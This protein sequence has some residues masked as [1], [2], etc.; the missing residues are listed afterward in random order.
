MTPLDCARG[1]AAFLKK[2]M[3][4]DDET[5]RDVDA[6]TYDDRKGTVRVF[7]GFLPLAMSQEQAQ[8]LCPAIVVRPASVADSRDASL[9]TILLYVTTYDEDMQHGH[10]ELYHLLEW[11]RQQLLKYNPVA[12]RYFIDLS[13]DGGLKTEIP[14]EQPYPQWWGVIECKVF[15]PQ[16]R[17]IFQWIT[18]NRK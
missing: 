16:V 14:D 7:A 1:F 11:T 5:L 18:Q 6:Y 13:G 4:A 17:P 2:R 3:Q 8:K 9:A 15:L 10:E 12:G